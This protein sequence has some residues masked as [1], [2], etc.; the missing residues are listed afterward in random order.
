MI[1]ALV[2]AAA[3]GGLP[4]DAL[5]TGSE[6]WAGGAAA[7]ACGE[8]EF[9]DP[10]ALGLLVN[11]AL[12]AALAPGIR[13]EASGGMLVSFE[14]RTRTVYDSFGSSIGE[15]EHS[16]NRGAD[17]LPGGLAV[18]ASG[19]S[20]LPEG[21]T[22]AAGLRI[23]RSFAY[24]YDRTVRNEYYVMTGTEELSIS[25]SVSEICGAV[26]F[27]P[28]PKVSFGLSGGLVSG[29]RDMRWEQQWID[30]TEDDA[31][32]N[33]SADLSGM[34]VRGSV[35]GSPDER[36][37]FCL[38]A[39]KHLSLG[40][41]GDTDGSLDLPVL[42]RAGAGI[43]PGNTLRTRFVAEVRYSRT[44]GAQFAGADMGLRDSWKASAGI[45]NTLPG[46]PV[47]RFGFAYERSALAASLDGM[48][49]TAGLGFRVSGCRLDIG[50]SFSP[51]RWEQ[52]SLPAI[53]SLDPGDSLTVEES[54]TLLVI[55]VGRAF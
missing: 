11:P 33:E 2:A 52:L 19:A 54:G 15:A 24:G 49:L 47:C 46:G 35:L 23:P 40:W 37:Q 16:F 32:V 12:A 27:T 48:A 26:A 5:F 17:L 34:I 51:R 13:V 22:V 43:L 39:E 3:L 9:L 18:S 44:S 14:K 20:W 6:S 25:G 55:S 53:Q 42:L 30:P 36:V 38:G 10:S 29:S 21:M 45:E 1:T 7:L 41:A 28:S 4:E 50:G 8:S 31:L